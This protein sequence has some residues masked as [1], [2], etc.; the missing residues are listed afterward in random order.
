MTSI[1][2]WASVG[3]FLVTALGTAYVVVNAETLLPENVPTHWGISGE[4][5]AFVPRKNV[6]P[7]L[8]VAPVGMLVMLVV[9]R[10]L[11]WLSPQQF[12]IEPFQ[13]TY[14]QIMFLVVVLFAYLHLVITLTQVGLMTD[15]TRWLMGGILLLLGG[16]GNL[17]GKV[18]RNFYMGVRTPWTLASDIVWER[19]HRLAAW[20]MVG[21]AA[22]GLLLLLVGVHPFVTFGIFMVAALVPV[23]Y[24]LWLYKWLEA[25]GELESQRAQQ[26]E[27]VAS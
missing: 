14:E 26:E 9:G 7:T 24:S 8:L 10:L 21:G 17:L 3:L 15:L 13:A 27:Q 16:I 12:A 5:D 4:P 6:L 23:G 20:L 11:P 1:W 22:V 25:R 18:R 2:F 19:T